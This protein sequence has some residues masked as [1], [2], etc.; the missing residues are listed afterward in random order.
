MTPDLWNA[1]HLSIPCE[2][3]GGSGIHSSTDELGGVATNSY[4]PDCDN[5]TRWLLR[6]PCN[7]GAMA[8]LGCPPECA[9][10]DFHMHTAPAHQSDCKHCQ[11]RTWLPVSTMEKVLGAIREK[12][13]QVLIYTMATYDMVR[14]R[15]IYTLDTLGWADSDGLRGPDAL[16]LALARALGWTPE[17]QHRHPRGGHESPR[18][19]HPG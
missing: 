3:C 13:W 2:A 4:C 8:W 11:G 19:R 12:G 15:D 18:R 7:A 9:E 16:N 1:E 6:T 5:G 10:E 17:S 14:I